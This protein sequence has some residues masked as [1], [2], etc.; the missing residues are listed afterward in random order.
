DRARPAPVVSLTFPSA[1]S[2]PSGHRA[3]PGRPRGAV[4]TGAARSPSTR[5]P[6]LLA[7]WPAPTATHARGPHAGDPRRLRAGG[8]RIIRAFVLPRA[9]RPP[10]LQVEP[11]RPRHP[12]QYRVCTQKTRTLT[13][14][15]PTP[16]AMPRATCWWIRHSVK[17]R[18]I[19]T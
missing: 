5:A 19:R 14:L 2:Q 17:R 16:Y 10:Q 3:G 8:G 4:S 6:T 18:R 13:A 12:V 7:A 11:G 1:T 15:L 9:R